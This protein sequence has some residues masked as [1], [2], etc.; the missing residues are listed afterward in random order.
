MKLA[1]K[2]LVVTGAG[3]GIGRAVALEA[4]RRRARVAAVDL[5]ATTLEETAT[6]AD[7]A[8]ST[9][10]LNVTDRVAVEALPA[11]V[12]AQL[13]VV[14]G[15]VHCAGIIQPFAKLQDLEYSAIEQVY[16]RQLVGD[17]VPEQ[18]V[19]AAAARAT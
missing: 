9:H 17:A 4:V 16:R 5:N 6:L 11:Q 18:N 12:I 7:G 14:D 3:S 2:V 13:G 1:G 15:L 8:V 10:T 19:P